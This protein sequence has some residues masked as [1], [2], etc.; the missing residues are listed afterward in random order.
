MGPPGLASSAVNGQQPQITKQ[1]RGNIHARMTRWVLVTMVVLAGAC[2]SGEQNDRPDPASTDARANASNGTDEVSPSVPDDLIDGSFDVG[3]YKLY[4]RCSGTGSPTIVY[5]HGSIPDPAFQ[6]HSSALSIQ[7][8]VDESNRMCV[9]DRA[10]IGLSDSVDGPLTGRTSVRDL[11]RLLAAAG[12]E[13]P[14]VLLPASF[15]GVIADIYAA[16][17]PDEVVAMV[18]LDAVVP[19]A[20]EAMK[21]FIPDNERLHPDDW[22]GTNEEIDELKVFDQ[23]RALEGNLPSIPMTYLASNE[24]LPDPKEDAAWRML[25]REFV[26][27]F[28][29]GRLIYLEAPHYMEPEIPERIARELERVIAASGAE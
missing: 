3:G 5:V 13:P 10:N 8:I 18:Q 22:I 11:H 19:D 12:V 2:T 15:G 26:D 9:Y 20:L 4:M 21:R 27:R 29:P 7:D 23:A 1:A 6:G 24:P 25:L 14:Y 28:S 16:T 17:Y